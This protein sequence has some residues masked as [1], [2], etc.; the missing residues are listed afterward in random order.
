MRSADHI[1]VKQ[2][3][4]C[5]SFLP[6]RRMLIRDTWAQERMAKKELVETEELIK[7]EHAEELYSNVEE[8]AREH[9][10]ADVDMDALD[11]EEDDMSDEHLKLN[12]CNA[13]L[14]KAPAPSSSSD[15][16][17]DVQSCGALADSSLAALDA[18]ED[19]VVP[20]SRRL[21]THPSNLRIR[22]QILIPVWNKASEPKPS[23]R[24]DAKES[25]D[26]AGLPMPAH[27]GP[28]PSA[29]P[30]RKT[31]FRKLKC[32]SSGCSPNRKADECIWCAYHCPGTEHSANVCPVH[33]NFPFRCTEESIFLPEQVCGK[34]PLCI[35]LKCGDH[36]KMPDCPRHNGEYE[37]RPPSEIK[38]RGQRT[39][40]SWVTDR[41]PY[42]DMRDHWFR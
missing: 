20:S 7:Q 42:L 11:M 33:Y 26:A 35:D 29:A 31:P 13:Y 12:L 22:K 4:M 23:K 25:D 8:E 37:G 39:E 19:T 27:P 32:A 9:R 38:R 3:R 10:L 40:R 6:L 41:H 18:D 5:K 2:E 17:A 16:D 1:Q 34:N 24:E 36:C 30:P 15:A 28:T 14:L 21:K